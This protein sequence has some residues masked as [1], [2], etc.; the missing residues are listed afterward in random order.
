MKT[1]TRETDRSSATQTEHVSTAVRSLVCPRCGAPDWIAE[2]DIIPGYALIL[3]VRDDGSIEWNG[4]TEVD[5][6]EQ[7]PASNPRE[8]ICLACDETLRD[9]DLGL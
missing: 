2:I 5:W 3:G 6:N 9:D 4:Q 8:F 1:K 7:G